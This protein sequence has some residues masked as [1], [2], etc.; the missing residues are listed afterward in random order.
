MAALATLPPHASP[1]NS[2][3]Q[4]W[5]RPA[6]QASV[7]PVAAG[8]THSSHSVGTHSSREGAAMRSAACSSTD[9]WVL[10]APAVW[11]AGVAE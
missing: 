11:A 6:P 2:Q 7:L 1:I 10:A 3:T 9:Q 4:A 8:A 5:Q